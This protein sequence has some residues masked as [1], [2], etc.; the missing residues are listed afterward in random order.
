[1]SPTADLARGPNPEPHGLAGVRNPHQERVADRLHLMRLVLRQETPHRAAVVV[2]QADGFLV[3]VHL[4]QGRVARDV[5]EQEGLGRGDRHARRAKPRSRSALATTVTEEAAMAAA[6]ST[7]SRST[8]HA[9]YSTPA[10]TGISVGN[11]DHAGCLACDGDPAPGRSPATG[12][13]T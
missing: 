6:A 13:P 2:D 9:G 10:A 3:S 12:R 5:G 4:R 1:M 8:P 11:A 7:G